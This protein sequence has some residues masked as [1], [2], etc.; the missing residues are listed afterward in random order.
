MKVIIYQGPEPKIIP[1]DSV[2]LVQEGTSFRVEEVGHT[3]A[4]KDLEIR[5]E[6]IDR[7]EIK[8][9]FITVGDFWLAWERTKTHASNLEIGNKLITELGL[10]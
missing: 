1:G 6:N 5:L 4:K 7:V 3:W 9:K 8:G 2:L 10:K